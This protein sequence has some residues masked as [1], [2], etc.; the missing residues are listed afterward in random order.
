MSRGAELDLDDIINF[1]ERGIFYYRIIVGDSSLAITE[2]TIKALKKLKEIEANDA[3]TK[4]K[5]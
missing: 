1:W 2:G 4:I 5:A 3:R